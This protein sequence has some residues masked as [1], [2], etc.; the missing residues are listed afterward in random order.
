MIKK[1]SKIEK[2]LKKKREKI[3]RKKDTIL[4]HIISYKK[5]LIPKHKHTSINNLEKNKNTSINNPERKKKK[6]NHL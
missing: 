1:I 5:Y 4:Y 2:I 6:K 3:E